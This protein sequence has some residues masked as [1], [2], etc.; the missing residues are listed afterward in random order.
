MV[1]LAAVTTNS[2]V[3]AVSLSENASGIDE[4]QHL[5]GLSQTYEDAGSGK[6]SAPE[7]T[8]PP[9][10]DPMALKNFSN[11]IAELK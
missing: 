3:E 2:I 7:K 5:L 6:D 10:V 1:A 8:K 4:N 11:S 9:H